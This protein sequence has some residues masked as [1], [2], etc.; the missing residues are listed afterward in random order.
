MTRT[1]LTKWILILQVPFCSSERVGILELA[2]ALVGKAMFPTISSV[3][4]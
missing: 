1:W 3:V 4:C 2:V